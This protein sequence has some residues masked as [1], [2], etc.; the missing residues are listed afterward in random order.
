MVNERLETV[1]V[2]ELCSLLHARYST[3][4][5]SIHKAQDHSYVS[6]LGPWKPEERASDGTA[7][8]PMMLSASTPS[9]ALPLSCVHTPVPGY[10]EEG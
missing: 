5:L 1:L 3:L 6:M 2:T 8:Q 10:I 7:R 4:P 9:R